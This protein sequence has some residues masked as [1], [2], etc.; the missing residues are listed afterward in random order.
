MM[1]MRIVADE[2]MPLV[3]EFFGA[4][5]E[6]RRL[7]GRDIRAADVAAA[8]ALLVRSVTRVDAA[9]LEGSAL[10]FVG[11]ATIGTDHL[12]LPALAARGITVAS[13]PG[14]NA[15]A[16]G[17]YVATVLASLAE[18][19]G[20][21][22][23]QRTLGIV[24]LGNTGRQVL[25]LARTLGFTVLACD[26]FVTE[27][28]AGVELVT[29]ETLLQRADILSLH[30]PLTRDGPHATRHWLDAGALA[31][32]RASL[33]INA[34][35]GAVVDNAALEAELRRRPQALTAVLDVWEGE[36]QLRAS[37]LPLLRY[38]SPHV[39]GYSQEGKW[40]GTAMIHQA[41]CRHFGLPATAS[42]AQLQPVVELPLLQAVQ[43][44]LA[45]L[46]Q[47]ACPLPRDDQ[48]LRASLQAVDPAQA[49]DALRKHYPPRHEFTAWRMRLPAGD[50]RGAVL[51]ALGFRLA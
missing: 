16:V 30:V 18:E 17:E 28:E 12:D 32:M 13:A 19:Q 43:P 24:G 44:G 22:P 40:R 35:R 37:L 36:P 11:T 4:L 3:P 2:N 5:A 15:R 7:P 45:A 10:R 1:A 31:G 33:L 6:I 34:S 20:W 41:F 29:R 14:C 23:A 42:L 51:A 21:T 8:D 49:F 47:Q 9:L 39:A 26:P 50:V 25:A 48:A 38:G 27:P 46:L